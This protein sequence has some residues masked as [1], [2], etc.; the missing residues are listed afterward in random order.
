MAH[1]SKEPALL[2]AFSNNEDVHTRTAALVYD[3][4]IELVTS[5]QRR[6]AKIVNYGIMY[7]AGPFRMSQE[8]GISMKNAKKIIENYF[9]TYKSIKS[10]IDKNINEARERGYVKTYF[11]RKRS[12]ANLNSPNANIVNAEKRAAVNMPI[13]GT[14]AELIKIAMIDISNTII[15]N[16][17]K[18]RMVL[19]VHDELLF[20]V[21]FSEEKVM[22]EII[23]DKMENSIK[24]DVPL[25]VDFKIG[26]NWYDIH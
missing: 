2:K 19:Q 11:G 8:L 20:E 3:L 21:P 7:G 16:N 24:L 10:Y 26:N 23:I 22:S 9:N 17:L 18:S 6:Q 4:P 12:T 25:K 13:Q 5:D 14:A 1:F 15:S